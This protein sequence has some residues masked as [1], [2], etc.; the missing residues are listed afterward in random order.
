VFSLVGQ[1]PDIPQ[2]ADIIEPLAV[3]L[4]PGFY[5]VLFGSGLFGAD[6]NAGLG[7]QNTPC[8]SPTF[9]QNFFGDWQSFND[10]GVRIVVRGVTVPAPIAGAS[11]PGLILASG[12]LLTWWRRRQKIA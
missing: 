3:T 8:C 11:L 5:A 9:L 4:N 10:P 12:G 1:L 6:G 7:F 2:G